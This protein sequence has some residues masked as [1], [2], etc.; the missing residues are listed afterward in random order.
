M[1]AQTAGNPFA[2]F[3]REKLQMNFPPSIEAA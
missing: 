2:I 1:P 3:W